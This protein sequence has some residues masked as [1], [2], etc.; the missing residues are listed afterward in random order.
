[1]GRFHLQQNNQVMDTKIMVIYIIREISS[2]K[3][4]GRTR[5]GRCPTMSSIFNP[6]IVK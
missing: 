3:E 2:E 5:E 6:T 1:M 4:K